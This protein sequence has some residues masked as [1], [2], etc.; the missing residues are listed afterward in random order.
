MNVKA[1]FFLAILLGTCVACRTGPEPLSFPESPPPTVLTYQRTTYAVCPI[2]F[3]AIEILK[4]TLGCSASNPAQSVPSDDPKMQRCQR[5]L[6]GCNVCA[7]LV[8]GTGPG[9][10]WTQPVCDGWYEHD[11]GTIHLCEPYCYRESPEKSAS[12][13]LHETI[14]NCQHEGYGQIANECQAYQAEEACFG[15]PFPAKAGVCFPIP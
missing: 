12:T 14:H 7:K 11:T 15:L 2:Y 10:D 8:D 3:P 5:A 4:K 6:R 9:L 13:L 1:F